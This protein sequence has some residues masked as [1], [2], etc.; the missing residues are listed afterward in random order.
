MRIVLAYISLILLWATTPLAIQWSSRGVGFLFGSAGRMAIGL[1]CVSLLLVLMRQPLVWRRKAL[2]T[3]LG[4]AMQLYASMILVY[5]AAQFIPSGWVSVVFGLVPL[6]TALIAALFLGERSLS[7]GKITSYL[8]GLGGLAV[9]FGSAITLGQTAVWAIVCLVGAAFLQA[10]SAIWV[11]RLNAQLPALVQVGGGLLVAV[12]AYGLTWWAFDG[13]WPVQVTVMTLGAILY[14]GVLAT[15]FGFALY[16]FILK[17]LA[18]TRVALISL[19]SPV[20]ALL[21]GHYLNHE[22][23]TVKIWLGVGLILAA[24]LL[25][26]F[27]DYRLR[28]A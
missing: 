19:L 27:A 7:F 16:Y 9:M 10:A 14:L 3:Y 12:P 6:L 13:Q 11:K 15:T 18:A 24:L 20:L 28:R 23:L 21:L 2:Y 1:A 22:Q 8:L 5:W 17:H 4:V 25:H 26:E